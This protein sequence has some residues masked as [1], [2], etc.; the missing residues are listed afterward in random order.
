MISARHPARVATVATL[1][2]AA[3]APGGGSLA[4]SKPKPPPPE[5][6]FAGVP[7]NLPPDSVRVRLVARGYRP[8]SQASDSFQVV[9]RGRLFEHDALVTGSL[10]DHRRLV[11]W[12]VLIA[13]RGDEYKWP[14]M[15]AVFDEVAQESEGRYGPPRSITEKYTFPA[16]KGDARQDEALRDGNLDLHWVWE[17]KNGQRLTVGMDE[18]VS[19]V[20]SYESPEWAGFQKRRRA[21]RASDL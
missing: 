6:L 3:L 2:L 16:R 13:S 10:D 7:W 18:N 11:R 4:A 21:K 9:F 14:D 12:V 8:V 1:A 17:S 15:K 19:V 20:L 5:Y